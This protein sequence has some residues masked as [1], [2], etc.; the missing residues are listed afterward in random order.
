MKDV[1]SCICSGCPNWE[2][3]RSGQKGSCLYC[4]TTPL[5]WALTLFNCMWA[6][7]VC[8]VGFAIHILQLFLCCCSRNVPDDDS[9]IAAKRESRMKKM[10]QRQKTRGDLLARRQGGQYRLDDGQV[11]LLIIL[12]FG[13]EK[14]FSAAD[15]EAALQGL[16]A[17]DAFTK[18]TEEQT[19][20]KAR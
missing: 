12:H 6:L 7:L 15:L 14:T 16:L 17:K 9:D 20:T 11:R 19:D 10:A 2:A 1:F 3:I 8:M 13:E 5:P 4:I 18:G